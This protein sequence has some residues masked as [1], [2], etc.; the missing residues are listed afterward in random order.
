MAKTKPSLAHS[1]MNKRNACDRTRQWRPLLLLKAEPRTQI[2]TVSF[3]LSAPP[4]NRQFSVP[5][6]WSSRQCM[7]RPKVRVA[8]LNAWAVEAGETR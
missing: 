6:A 7:S 1:A 2:G 8:T 5:P 3:V 4:T